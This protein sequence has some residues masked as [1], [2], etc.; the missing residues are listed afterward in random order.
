MNRKNIYTPEGNCS[1]QTKYAQIAPLK[2]I[3]ALKNLHAS[4]PPTQIP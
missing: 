3:P 4:L 2:P 1:V